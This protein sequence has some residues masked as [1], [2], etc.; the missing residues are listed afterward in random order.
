[1]TFPPN[2][3]E[4]QML[5][6]QCWVTA[7]GGTIA[8]ESATGILIDAN[9]AAEKLF[10]YAREELLGSHI[11]MLHPE[12]ERERIKAEFLRDNQEPGIHTGFY[13]QRKD[14]QC[15]P[16]KI[17]SWKS[18]VL[19]DRFVTICVYIDISYQVE[20]EHR[21]STQ[22]WAL[23]AYAGAALALGRAET[24]A[25]LKQ[26]ICEAITKESVY[27][28]A[29]IGI[30]EDGPEKKIRIAAAAGSGIEYM[31]GLQVNWSED[32]PVGRGPTGIC[33]RTGTVKI[34][35]DSE[36]S[37]FFAPW[38]ERARQAGIRSSASIP[39]CINGERRGALMVYS[40]HP[41]AFEPAAIEV[42]QHLAGQIGHGIH[43]LEQAQLLR[44]E[45]MRLEK[46]Q[47]QL[48]DALSAMVSPIITAMEM[49]DPYTSGHQSRVAE[50]A[51]A[52][53][54]ELGWPEER[55]QGL[56][57]A[58]LVHDIG[59][60]STPAEILTKP[61]RLT[62]TERM[63]IN[64]HPEAGYAI[65][66]DVPFV[67]PI[68]EMVRQHHEKLDGSGYP[69]GL[70]GDA[71]LPEAKVLAVADIVEAMASDRPY[72]RAIDLDR[73]LEEIEEQAGGLLDAEVVR[74]CA[75][76]FR[77]KRLT[78]PARQHE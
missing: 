23:S 21:L 61:G 74:A 78:L 7:P 40:V 77:E 68:A 63:L 72:R 43:A 73:V 76:L 62:S 37:E 19:G 64:E 6:E 54:R 26:S 33:I 41:N 22:N 15:L 12:A 34:L 65:L 24:V 44:A 11:A 71:I 69:F 16:V 52:I 1:M 50:I 4:T 17:L 56:R 70:K 3:H 38:R 75:A 39:F 58:S 55:L 9:P 42:F 18:L 60:I 57:L 20:Q 8:F 28:L 53:G 5:Y 48:S 31:E 27:A 51:V 35:E 32:D 29:W 59:K 13:L 14:G 2:T 47:K 36:T 10:G 46:M 49:R 30:A 66:K 25:E 67:W 45:Q